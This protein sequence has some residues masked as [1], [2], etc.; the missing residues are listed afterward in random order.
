[1]F[2]KKKLVNPPLNLSDDD[3]EIMSAEATHWN[4]KNKISGELKITSKYIVFSSTSFPDICLNF[5]EIELTKYNN[6]LFF[7]KEKLTIV[8]KNEEITFHL[9]YSK[10]WVKLIEKLLKFNLSSLK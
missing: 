1:M 10:D 3:Y 9:N 2:L 8:V 4:G 7:L 6:F 5:N